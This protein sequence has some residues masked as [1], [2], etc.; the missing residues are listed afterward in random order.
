MSYEMGESVRRRA[1]GTNLCQRNYGKRN[2]PKRMKNYC[3][4]T[5]HLFD[6][7]EAIAAIVKKRKFFC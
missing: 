3:S 2:K 6:P 4:E 5:K 7:D 1:Y